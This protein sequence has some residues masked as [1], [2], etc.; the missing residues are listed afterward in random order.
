M[1]SARSSVDATRGRSA[2][3]Q[4]LPPFLAGKLLV[5]LVAV[6]TVWS[7]SGHAGLPTYAEVV[8]PFGAWD[9]E[10]YRSIA[11]HG[12]PSGPLDLDPGAPGH[13]WAFLPGFPMLMRAVML[14]VPDSTTA[15]MLV[16]AVCEL[17][18]LVYLAKLV[19]LER[20]GDADS[21]RF[22]VWLLVLYPYALF[23][24]AAY[25][26]SPFL[27][28]ATASLYYMR[29]GEHV[30]ASVLAALS[31]AVRITGLA[32]IPALLVEYVM[33]RG[34]NPREDVAAALLPA[35]PLLLFML[36]A[37]AMTGD[38]FAY[39]HVEASA[40]FN[41]T[42]AWPWSGL[43]ETVRAAGDNT[44]NTSLFFTTEV[45][46]GV[47][48]L[49]AIVYMA[50]RRRRYALSLTAYSAATWV[51]SCSFVYWLGVQRYMIAI[52][53][54]FIVAADLTRNRPELRVALLAVSAGCLAFFTSLLA[55]GAFVA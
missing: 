24:T 20:P 38:A 26:E 55:T 45:V 39:W 16:S 42:P 40:S 19:R 11:Q 27:A 41:R 9:G 25:T 14:L 8:Q 3:A 21:A 18:A 49:V 30:R 4:V 22:T 53:P 54:V 15:G 23:L 29:R 52:V 34:R 43:I 17:I 6:L 48:F 2:L 32:L 47:L 31:A 36:Y 28:A 51:L 5:L 50:M 44:G 12:Y 10:S 46:L 33:R 13:L 1:A 7:R 35:V 37:H